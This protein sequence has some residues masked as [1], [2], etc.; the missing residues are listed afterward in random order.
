MGLPF[1][2]T[3]A[4]FA[5]L[6][7][8]FI[9]SADGIT[10]LLAGGYAPAQIY[11]LSGAVVAGLCAATTLM[12]SGA[13]SLPDGLRTD[14]R[15]AMGLRSAATVAAALCFFYAFRLLPFA[16]VFIFIGLM[17]LLAGLMSAPILRERV[18]PGA[19]LALAAGFGGVIRVFPGGL[20]SLTAGHAVA[21]G[22]SALGTLS[23]TLSRYIGRHEQN[24]LAQ[25]LYPNLALSLVM[26]P[27]LPF[28][29]LPMPMADVVWALSYA[30]LLF[31]ARWLLVAALRRLP[32]Y[33]VTPLMNL[34]FVW[35][36]LIGALGFG[37]LP[38]QGTWM[39]AAV[40]AAS[41]IY[42]VWDQLAPRQAVWGRAVITARQRVR[43]S[44]AAAMRTDP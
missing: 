25:V 36:V 38:G 2:L 34:Q 17:P 22:A 18:R 27:V 30:G 39:G 10:K 26:L 42:L 14:C 43:H 19:W 16:E 9:A 6:Y 41:G 1:A 24:V 8:G 20:S 44:A 28:V 13:R 35:M 33:A 4:V 5:V 7:T 31:G 32:S 21:L 29:W 15:L 3:G 37:E 40:I 23:I 12:R 11:A